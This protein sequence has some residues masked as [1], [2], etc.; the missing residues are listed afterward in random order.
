MSS[1]NKNEKI[2]VTRLVRHPSG[3]WPSS[4]CSYS[5]GKPHWQEIA[6]GYSLDDPI[7][8]EDFI[9]RL[10]A[11]LGAGE[12]KQIGVTRYAGASYDTL[13]GGYGLCTAHKVESFLVDLRAQLLASGRETLYG[14]T[15][16]FKSSYGY[17]SHNGQRCDFSP[18]GV[19]FTMVPGMIYTVG[20]EVFVD[21]EGK[22]HTVIRL[23]DAGKSLL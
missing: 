21:N 4:S 23:V 2:S 3:D 12:N 19:D 7:R 13:K 18:V 14:E 20:S 1:P 5:C 9:L 17:R 11:T 10:R 8:I 6:I 22:E 16:A 15:D